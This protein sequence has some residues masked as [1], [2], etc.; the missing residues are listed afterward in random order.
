M[1]M[2]YY[3]QSQLGY[4]I[5]RQVGKNGH[6]GITVEIQYVFSGNWR[7]DRESSVVILIILTR[8]DKQT[9]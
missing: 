3:Y 2:V 1:G 5:V 7:K 4:F 8:E 9:K 6:N